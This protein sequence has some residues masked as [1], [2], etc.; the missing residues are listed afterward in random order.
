MTLGGSDLS[1]FGAGDGRPQIISVHYFVRRKDGIMAVVWGLSRKK[2][3]E[4]EK[5]EEEQEEET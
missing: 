3:E 4:G 5:D 2:A 1:L